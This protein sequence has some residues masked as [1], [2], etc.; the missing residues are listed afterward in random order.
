M[1]YCMQV[2]AVRQYYSDLAASDAPVMG[3][4]NPDDNSAGQE[5]AAPAVHEAN[6]RCAELV[7]AI[8]ESGDSD[9]LLPGGDEAAAICHDSSAGAAEEVGEQTACPVQHQPSADPVVPSPSKALA[10]GGS[11]TPDGTSSTDIES[12][13]DTS[14][15]RTG[16]AT[17][18]GTAKNG[19][20]SQAATSPARAGSTSPGGTTSAGNES[21][22]VTSPAF[23]YA[24]ITLRSSAS[25]LSASSS[26][27]CS[28]ASPSCVE[29]GMA[30]VVEPA[31]AVVILQ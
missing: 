7:S 21:Q 28:T 14:P 29:P 3:E 11:T 18:N 26:A 31:A 2:G 25:G 12:R 4:W 9:G 24:S 20:E 19:D 23:L 8:M 17:P 22:E 5:E 27:C 10:D 1:L 30:V 6:D 16:H 15:A 13:A